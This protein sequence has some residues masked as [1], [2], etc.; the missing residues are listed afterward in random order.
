MSF[1]RREFALTLGAFGLSGAG[2]GAYST[3]LSLRFFSRILDFLEKLTR[4]FESD[5][6]VCI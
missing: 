2:E 6:F 5:E 4:L 3:L 1:T